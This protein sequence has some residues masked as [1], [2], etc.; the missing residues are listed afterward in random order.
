MLNT[1][2]LGPGQSP[3]L[4]SAP[5]LLVLAQALSH[6]PEPTV[7]ALPLRDET[8]RP[9]PD[10]IRAVLRFSEE[11]IKRAQILLQRSF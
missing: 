3:L 8:V 4:R 10:L 9:P 6:G 5:V 11:V 2:A 7:L 1:Y